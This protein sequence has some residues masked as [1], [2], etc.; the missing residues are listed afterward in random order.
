VKAWLSPFVIAAGIGAASLLA[1]CTTNPAT[2]QQSYTAFMSSDEEKRVGAEEHQKVIKEYGGAFNH[3]GI[4]AYVTGIG[5]KL[6]A[7]SEFA[8]QPF[9][10]TVLDSEI[11]NAF[12]L[13]GGYVYVTRGLLALASSEAELASVLGHEIGHVTGR[14]T[15][16]RVSQANTANILT[17]G[18]AVLAG[19]LT[20]SSE[21][22]SA[23]G[24]IV[25]TGAAAY[26]QSFSREQ[27]FE[28]DSLGVR[29]MTRAGYDP[30]AAGGFLAKLQAQSELDAKL[31]GRD[32]NAGGDM[33]A[34]HPRTQDRVAKAVTEAAQ[35]EGA[36][37]Q[38]ALSK[39]A[40][41]IG[42]EPFLTRI[43]GL[44]YGADPREGVVRG[45]SFT[46]PPQRVR[47]S[48]PSGYAVQNGAE[49][50]LIAGQ[51][52]K[53]RYDIAKAST[54]A[55]DAVR[56][57]GQSYGVRGL[58]RIAVPGGLDAATGVIQAQTSQKQPVLVRLLVIKT[59]ANT[60]HRF[61]IL[62]GLQSGPEVDR[63]AQ[64]LASS[65]TQLSAAEAAAFKPLRVEI[66][67]AGSEAQTRQ[68]ASQMPTPSGTE[69]VRLFEILNGLAPG[70]MPAPGT[71][72]KLL[73][74]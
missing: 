6:V 55:A 67:S 10:F 33:M 13:P 37:A 32:P 14:H 73:R 27:E 7:T 2:G 36:K 70:A 11:V 54:P 5:N 41:E 9:T 8:G 53:A 66:V 49:A 18:L 60:A 12:A 34:S 23:V 72:I 48:A 71:K 35:G 74:S 46:L 58:S 4:A 61:Q 45:S 16:Q 30:A 28:A 20:G 59:D 50:V 38:A 57:W 29:Y 19:V 17:G 68:Q 56:A 65:L 22:G 62:G 69:S 31:A 43:S 51:A 39:P 25:G 3:N 1:G 26:V 15:A 52:A 40:T 42:R 64:S 63:L 21:L 44:P 24:D 47:W